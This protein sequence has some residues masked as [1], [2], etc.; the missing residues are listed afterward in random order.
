MRFIFSVENRE[1]YQMYQTI[2]EEFKEKLA[3]YEQ[4]LQTAYKLIDKPKQLYG[5]HQSCNIS[6]L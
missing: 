5:L 4:V 2:T 6:L 3:V 1:D